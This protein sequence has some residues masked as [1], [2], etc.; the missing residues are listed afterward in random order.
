MGFSRESKI[1]NHPISFLV[2]FD[3]PR[4][5]E[6]ILEYIYNGHVVLSE[7]EVKDLIEAAVQYEV[8]TL[9]PVLKQQFPEH[10]E[11]FQREEERHKAKRSGVAIDDDYVR[12]PTTSRPLPDVPDLP[13]PFSEQEPEVSIQM[14]PKPP[15]RPSSN[16]TSSSG[17][18]EGGKTKSGK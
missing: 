5:I 8:V 2:E 17:S 6:M 18:G 14:I 16:G 15:S 3:S 7:G 10:A 11:L 1:E 12:D 13:Q 9:I 4:R